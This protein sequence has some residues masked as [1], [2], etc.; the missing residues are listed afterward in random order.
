MNDI[1]IRIGSDVK[2]SEMILQALDIGFGDLKG[3]SNVKGIMEPIPSAVVEGHPNSSKIFEMTNIDANNMI[4]TTEEGTHFVGRNAL[5]MPTAKSKRT[6]VRDRANDK[7]SRVLFKTAMGLLAPDQGSGDY[8]IHLIT[9]LPNDDFDLTIKDHLQEFIKSPFEVEFH[10][11]ADRTIKK[12]ITVVSHSILRQ[13]EGSVTFNQFEFTDNAKDFMKAKDPLVNVLGIIDSGHFTTDFALFQEGVI[14]ED[15]ATNGSTKGVA[16]AYKILRRYIRKTFDE[17]G[18][19][20]SPTEQDLDYAVRHKK[21]IYMSQ[22][23]DVE[24]EVKDAAEEVAHIIAKDVLEAWGNE[25][26]RLDKILITGGGANVFKEALEKEF[27]F[28]KKQ[29]FVIVEN[30]QFANAIGYYMYGVLDIADH[31]SNQSLYDTYIRP[32]F[33]EEIA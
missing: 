16:E 13:P 19:D 7:A 9:G 21:I 10:L 12:R 14:V 28:Y 22:E 6:Q 8:E 15:P 23:F 18:F 3:V 31:L 11:G 32:V 5:H 4:V 26:N 2:Q 17:M 29:S 27:E 30:P 1:N 33:K 24:Q 20:F 25:T